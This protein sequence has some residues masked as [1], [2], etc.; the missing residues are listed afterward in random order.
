VAPEEY[1]G[2]IA[3]AYLATQPEWPAYTTLFRLLEKECARYGAGVDDICARVM[4]KEPCGYV[5]AVDERI[6]VPGARR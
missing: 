3:R 4:L 1:L 5:P 2:L 6:P